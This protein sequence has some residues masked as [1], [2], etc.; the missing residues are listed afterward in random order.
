M[1]TRLRSLAGLTEIT[2]PRCSELSSA[3]LALAASSTELV[4]YWISRG[5]RAG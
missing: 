5:A 1:Y 2:A 4:F 3:S